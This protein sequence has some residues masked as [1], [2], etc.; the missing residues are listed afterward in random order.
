LSSTRAKLKFSSLKLGNAYLSPDN[1][2]VVR[3][4]LGEEEELLMESIDFKK[5]INQD[6][7]S[8]PMD[9]AGRNKRSEENIHCDSRFLG[10]VHD[11]PEHS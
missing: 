10:S 1:N 8:G 11:S 2:N 5:D 6:S 3:L 7:R 4:N 9:E